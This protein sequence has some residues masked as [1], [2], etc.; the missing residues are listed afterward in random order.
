MSKGSSAATESARRARA[1][2]FPVVV[3]QTTREVRGLASAPGV[4]REALALFREAAPGQLVIAQPVVGPLAPTVLSLAD[5]RLLLAEATPSLE[6]VGPIEDATGF[7]VTVPGDPPP[8][9]ERLRA[10]VGG[11]Y[12]WYE[13]GCF[14]EFYGVP[15]AG[16]RDGTFVVGI[17]RRDQDMSVM[18]E[19][20][21][22][23]RFANAL[24]GAD[25]LARRIKGVG[26]RID[27]HLVAPGRQQRAEFLACH[28]DFG[29]IEVQKSGGVGARAY[30]RSGGAV[31]GFAGVSDPYLVFE[32]A[33]IARVLGAQ[34]YVTGDWCTRVHGALMR[35]GKCLEVAVW[36][37]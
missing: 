21:E 7:R 27:L 23:R 11:E 5:W 34:P 35:A 28:R 22:S 18:A 32:V 37:D 4:V 13:D 17:D 3:S 12:A 30:A 1:N 19:P 15:L 9:L 33:A 26:D 10:A 31:V 14:L 8:P 2:G 25:V 29:A 16:V 36:E 20:S 24:V 6:V